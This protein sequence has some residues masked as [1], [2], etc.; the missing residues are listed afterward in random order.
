MTNICEMLDLLSDN[1]ELM[2]A[3]LVLAGTH[4]QSIQLGR[5]P[6]DVEIANEVKAMRK[7]EREEALMTKKRKAVEAGDRGDRERMKRLE[8]LCAAQD[9][10]LKK[11]EGM[12]TELHARVAFSPLVV[13]PAPK[14]KGTKRRTALKENDEAALVALETEE[15]GDAATEMEEASNASIESKETPK[16]ACT[17]LGEEADA[18][19]VVKELADAAILVKELADAAIETGEGTSVDTETEG[20][21]DP[22]SKAEDAAPAADVESVPEGSLNAS[23]GLQAPEE[24][25]V[26]S[27]TAEEQLEVAETMAQVSTERM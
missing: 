14:H 6:T 26:P 12:L 8:E 20:A 19:M 11:V 17:E 1:L 4:A 16:E 23:K 25:K 13:P 7:R 22:D 21:D 10:R 2:L 18:A 15:A 3:Y 24:E 27:E 9:E 5:K